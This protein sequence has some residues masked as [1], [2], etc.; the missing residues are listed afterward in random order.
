VH[1]KFCESM[2]VCQMEQELEYGCIMGLW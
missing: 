1:A 2:P